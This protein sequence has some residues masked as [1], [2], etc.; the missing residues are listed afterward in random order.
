[1]LHQPEP[2]ASPAAAQ[3][4]RSAL[5]SRFGPRPIDLPSFVLFAFL[6][7]GDPSTRVASS[8]VRRFFERCLFLQGEA[9]TRATAMCDVAA[10]G[11]VKYRDFRSYM[12]HSDQERQTRQTVQEVEQV[13]ELRKDTRA[14]LELVDQPGGERAPAESVLD[15]KLKRRGRHLDLQT[16]VEGLVALLDDVRLPSRAAAQLLDLAVAA[17]EVLQEEEKGTEE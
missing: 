11:F 12:A 13:A 3:L 1:M 16:D 17:A 2:S 14:V 9:A 5:L 10:C 7:G 15:D 8:T 6:G 4:L